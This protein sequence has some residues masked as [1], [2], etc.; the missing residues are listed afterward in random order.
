MFSFEWQ[1]QIVSSIWSTV[2][3]SGWCVQMLKWEHIRVNLLRLVP[4]QSYNY[5]MFVCSNKS[6]SIYLYMF[7]C[8]YADRWVPWVRTVTQV[9]CWVRLRRMRKAESDANCWRV[10]LLTGKNNFWWLDL[11]NE[12]LKHDRNLCLKFAVPSVRSRN[13][14][15]FAG[16]LWVSTP[17]NLWVKP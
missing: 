1:V 14:F 4:G 9:Q 13:C 16:A 6:V 12:S 2:N 11:G 17:K 7:I 10:D 8:F 5:V 15:Y 3:R